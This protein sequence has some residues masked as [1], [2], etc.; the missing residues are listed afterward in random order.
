MPKK[1]FKF[2]ALDES[3]YAFEAL[4]QALQDEELVAEGRCQ[5]EED[6]A[7]LEEGRVAIPEGMEYPLYSYRKIPAEHWITGQAEFEKGLLSIREY[8]A[9]GMQALTFYSDIRCEL[10]AIQLC[11]NPTKEERAKPISRTHILL[12][13]AYSAFRSKKGSADKVSAEGLWSFLEDNYKDFGFD[14]YYN[15]SDNGEP[16]LS[17]TNNNEEIKVTRRNFKNIVS[18][19][20]TGKLALPIE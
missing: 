9:E 14:D 2:T 3:T 13:K 16:A 10:S 1:Y 19:F 6:I 17:Y 18:K 11:N 5:T 8:T 20:N 7:D 15:V 12:G 4:L